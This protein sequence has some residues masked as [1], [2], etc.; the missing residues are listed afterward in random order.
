MPG[1]GPICARSAEVIEVSPMLW[2]G[3]A[4]DHPTKP[5][6]KVACVDAIAAR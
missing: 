5:P 1:V 3:T 2:P 4:P 6:L